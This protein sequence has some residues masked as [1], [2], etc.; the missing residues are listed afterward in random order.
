MPETSD[1]P[2]YVEET[3]AQIA[4]LHTAHYREAAAAKRFVIFATAHFARPRTLVL[5]AVAMAAWLALNVWLG[6]YWAKAPVVLS[7]EELGTYSGGFGLAEARAQ[8]AEARA[9]RLAGADPLR[10]KRAGKART[11]VPTFGKAAD[12]YI[13]AHQVSWKTAAYR[14]QWKHSLSIRSTLRRC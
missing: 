3:V 6:V 11:A 9:R 1:V 4:A 8:H 14:A 5:I 7:Q 10:E 2:R 12:D 13:A